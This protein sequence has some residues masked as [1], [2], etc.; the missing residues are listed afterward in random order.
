MGWDMKQ[1]SLPIGPNECRFYEGC[2]APLCPLNT[3]LGRSIWYPGEPVCHLKEAPDWARK[4]R[5]IARLPGIDHSRCFTIR[6]LTSLA[7]VNKG[8]QGIPPDD[9]EEEK[10][11]LRQQ[12][13]P[14]GIRRTRKADQAKLSTEF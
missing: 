4:Q 8:L 5:R 7:Q 3:N 13:K 1:L 14:R 10:A 12:R 2:T 6:M 11:W 9:P